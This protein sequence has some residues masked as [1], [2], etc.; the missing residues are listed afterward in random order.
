VTT[1][2]GTHPA[3]NLLPEMSEEQFR[4]LVADIDANGMRHPIIV[5]EEGLIIDGRHRH[6]ACQEL[7]RPPSCRKFQGTE[8]EKIALILSENIHRRHLTT[9]QRAAIA[10]DLTERLKVAASERP[11]AGKKTLA[12]FEAK[13]KAT[14]QAAKMTGVSRATVE[15]AVKRKK[16]DP[17]AHEAAKR[18]DKPKKSIAE[19]TAEANKLVGKL[20]AKAPPEA[21]PDPDKA[22]PLPGKPFAAPACPFTR[23]MNSVYKAFAELNSNY[24]RRQIISMLYGYL[25]P[26][27]RKQLFADLAAVDAKRERFERTIG[28]AE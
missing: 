11:K 20:K 5:D 6:R 1:I 24:D 27:E 9:D 16:E 14:A 28:G 15:R 3:C 12:S 21:P 23:A 4:E 7:D 2:T 8:A 26:E 10:A 22:S 25:P 18:G 13:G 19:L 17:A